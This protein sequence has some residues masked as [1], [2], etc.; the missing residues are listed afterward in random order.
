MASPSP[1]ANNFKDIAG[2]RFGDLVVIELTERIGHTWH[3]RCQCDCGRETVAD[4]HNIRNGT[5]KS[6]GCRVR[7]NDA[8]LTHGHA[9]A[10]SITPEYRSWQGMIRRCTNPDEPCFHRY[11]G[12]GIKVYQRWLDSF[13]A[14]FADM[15]PKPTPT[16]TIERSDN[17]GHY[18]PGNCVWATKT[19]QARNRRSA[20]LLLF[21]GETKPL[22][23]WAEITGLDRSTIE[24]RLGLGWPIERVLTEPLRWQ[25]VTFRGETLRLTEWARRLGISYYTLHR[26]LKDG[27]SVEEAFKPG[28]KARSKSPRRPHPAPYD[29]SPLPRASD[30]G[31]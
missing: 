20:R 6:C 31:P 8:R 11:G 22:W 26:R 1:K 7:R 21:R 12:R 19:E 2:Q 13:E 23:E 3:W 16:H 24:G 5:T 9:R 29:R 15:G 30:Q 10:G 27:C 17:N 25:T 4:G 28:R 14:F 18:E